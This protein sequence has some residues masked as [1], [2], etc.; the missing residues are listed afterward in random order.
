MMYS[1]GCLVAYNIFHG[2][3]SISYANL[4]IRTYRQQKFQWP[5]QYKIGICIKWGS[6]LSLDW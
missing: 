4:P 5:K 3:L 6:V 1:W 2:G